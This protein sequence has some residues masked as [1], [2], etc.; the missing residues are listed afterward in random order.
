MVLAT[1]TGLKPNM[2]LGQNWAIL[3]I[4]VLL[5]STFV[6][7]AKEID[8]RRSTEMQFH[9]KIEILDLLTRYNR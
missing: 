9:N 4:C 6:L 2:F 8:T 1:T 5:V 3:L 7:S